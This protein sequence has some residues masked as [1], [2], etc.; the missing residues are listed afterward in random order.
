[1]NAVLLDA[2][3]KKYYKDKEVVIHEL[4]PDY[5]L[6]VISYW[7]SSMKFAVSIKAIKAQP[8]TAPTISIWDIG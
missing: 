3:Q 4:Y 8:D 2:I 1:M 7:E 6:A 5:H